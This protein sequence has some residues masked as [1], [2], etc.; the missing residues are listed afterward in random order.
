[1]ERCRQRATSDEKMRGYEMKRHIKA[2]D[3]SRSASHDFLSNYHWGDRR[4]YELCVNT[5]SVEILEIVPPL[6]MLAK[7]YFERRKK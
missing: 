5:T 7:H 1:M 6:A 3:K 4:V 2:I